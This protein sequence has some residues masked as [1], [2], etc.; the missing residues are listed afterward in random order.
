MDM[1]SRSEAD[2][3]RIGAEEQMREDLKKTFSSAIDTLGFKG[4]EQREVL[5][6]FR[7][8]SAGCII[9]PN[10]PASPPVRVDILAKANLKNARKVEIWISGGIQG[11]SRLTLRK[12]YRG[13]KEEITGTLDMWNEFRPSS[14]KLKGHSDIEFTILKGFSNAISRI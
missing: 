2:G 3:E 7:D 6:I 1:S 10:D 4:T 9:N 13:Q 14:L 8:R 11:P 12:N 5:G